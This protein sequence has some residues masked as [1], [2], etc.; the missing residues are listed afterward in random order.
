MAYNSTSNEFVAL[1]S[2]GYISMSNSSSSDV[3]T[4]FSST[5]YHKII[6]CSF[7]NK[8]I[9][10]SRSGK[11]YTSTDG[12]NWVEGGTLTGSS[13]WTDITC[14]NNEILVIGQNYLS[15]STDGT[16]WTTPVSRQGTL[17]TKTNEQFVVANSN[18]YV[19]YSRD[20]ERWTN[21]EQ[22]ST[23]QPSQN[24]FNWI[25]SCYNNGKAYL[26]DN[27]GHFTTSSLPTA[28][29]GTPASI[30][31]LI[32]K[33]SGSVNNSPFTLTLENAYLTL[34]PS[35]GTLYAWRNS[36]PLMLYT[37]TL[38]PSAGDSVFD[39][40]GSLVGVIQ[41]Y[42]PNVGAG[43]IIVYYNKTSATVICNRYVTGDT[44]IPDVI[45]T[46]EHSLKSNSTYDI[47][48]SYD[49]S[50]YTLF[51]RLDPL[52][53]GDY[54]DQETILYY[55][56]SPVSLN[57]N[58][59]LAIGSDNNSFKF[60]GTVD[61]ANCEFVS[62]GYNW[63]GATR[64]TSLLSKTIAPSSASELFDPSTY[65][66]PEEVPCTLHEGTIL[67]E[68]LFEIEP[69]KKYNI[70]IEYTGTSY[71]VLQLE[72]SRTGQV[73]YE[74]DSDKIANTV[75]QIYIGAEP[76]YVDSTAHPITENPFTSGTVYLKNVSITQ[77]D[78]VWT[79]TKEVVTHIPQLLQYY[80]IPKLNRSQYSTKDFCDFDRI[81]TVLENTFTGNRDI[82]NFAN[83]NG[84]TLSV[85]ANLKNS[86]PKILLAKSD[87]VSTPYFTLTFIENT[88]EFI[89]YGINNKVYKLSRKLEIE[90]ISAFT[91]NPILLTVIYNPLGDTPTLSLY[92]N[93]DKVIEEI[94]YFGTLVEHNSAALVN[95]LPESVI[96]DL[97]EGKETE[98]ESIDDLVQKVQDNVDF[99]IDG[100]IAVSGAISEEELYYITNLSDTNF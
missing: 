5:V 90:E 58:S 36:T 57:K 43:Q 7:L 65:A 1:S 89:I 81:I 68:N 54:P 92:R 52:D 73:L 25:A 13:Y 41:R 83:P 50:K 10:V 30:Q 82:I 34:K 6:Y 8:Y 18:G 45:L 56:K 87:S 22:N 4:P 53:T 20:G 17:V 47:S 9:A 75:N 26:F 95:Y 96:R 72:N 33:S 62:N 48:I 46:S 35:L 85:K 21:W 94:V 12:R 97:C 15:T 67:N 32:G 42:Y 49:G 31:Y 93:N 78:L 70:V 99:Y 74:L 14:S 71:R 98:S 27:N 79:P 86:E 51:Y 88:L 28:S 80:H 55:S 63:I 23:L 59:S 2:T 77:D 38:V 39:E 100:L 60:M 16:T 69:N 19:A 66:I 29:V 40:N 64:L 24:R 76:S 3:L 91:S 84:F 11:T 37:S 61:I 44:Q